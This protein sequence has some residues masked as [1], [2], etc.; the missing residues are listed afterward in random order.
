MISS[1]H[2]HAAVL[3]TKGAT[4]ASSEDIDTTID[5]E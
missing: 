5:T 2:D 4:A 1:C 3:R